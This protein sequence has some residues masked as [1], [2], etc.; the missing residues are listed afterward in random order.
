MQ[1]QQ[2]L[3]AANHLKHTP[4]VNSKENRD[5]SNRLHKNM[6]KKSSDYWLVQASQEHG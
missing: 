6:A 5:A 1:F 4:T 3:T 2:Q